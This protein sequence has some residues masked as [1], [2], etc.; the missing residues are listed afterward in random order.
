MPSQMIREQSR[1]E[2]SRTIPICT[3]KL[4]FLDANQLKIYS[5]R[6]VALYPACTLSVAVSSALLG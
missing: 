5:T 6:L 2:Q 1:A 3:Y 4:K